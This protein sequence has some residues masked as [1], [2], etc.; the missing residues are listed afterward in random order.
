MPAG[1]RPAI[2]DA[3]V[4]PSNTQTSES[5]IDLGQ[6]AAARAA[7]ELLSTAL[8]S[9]AGHSD[10]L[11]ISQLLARCPESQRVAAVQAYWRF[12]VASASINW[13]QDEEKRL[14]EIAVARKLGAV[15][16]PILSTARAAAAARVTDAEL[17]LAKAWAAIGIATHNFAVTATYSPTDVPLVAPYN[18]FYSQIFAG[19]ENERAWEIDRTLPACCRTISDRAAAVQSAASAI[20]YAEQAHAKSEVDLGTVLSCINDLHNQR[21]EF[22]NAVLKYN[23]DVAEYAAAAAPPGTSPE[24][25]VAML[26]HSKPTERLS[27]VPDKA[28][29]STFGSNLSAEPENLRGAKARQLPPPPTPGNDG[30]IPSTLRPIEPEPLQSVQSSPGAGSSIPPSTGFSQRAASPKSAEAPQQTREIETPIRAGQQPDPFAMPPADNRY[31]NQYDNRY[32]YRSE[33]R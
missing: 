25:F 18:T 27:A 3:E 33:G 31:N 29:I 10:S 6:Q 22:L 13:A 7:A 32:D 12:S 8:D 20:H 1:N 17:D 30:W 21:R 16:G 24:K 19:R 4:V 28:A 5:T 11:S 23:L 9:S 14:E 15:E 26:I 2:S